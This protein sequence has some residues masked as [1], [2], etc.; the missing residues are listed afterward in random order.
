MV[1]VVAE[2]TGALN[3]AVRRAGVLR[4]PADDRAVGVV[5]D[6]GSRLVLPAAEPDLAVKLLQ[7]LLV[8]EVGCHGRRANHPREAGCK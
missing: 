1:G 8:T 3:H 6:A 5:N 2:A 4:V 7:Q